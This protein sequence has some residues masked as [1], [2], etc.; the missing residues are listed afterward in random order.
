VLL[1]FG[2]LLAILVVVRHRANIQR[3]MAGTESRVG[4]KKAS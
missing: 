3:L 4:K 2:I 1:G